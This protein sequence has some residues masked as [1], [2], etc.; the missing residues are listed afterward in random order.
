ME[1]EARLGTEE[2]EL[3]K[4]MQNNEGWLASYKDQAAIARGHTSK[5]E[6][7]AYISADNCIF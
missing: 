6:N 1:V 3:A 2:G 7:R 5:L 4:R